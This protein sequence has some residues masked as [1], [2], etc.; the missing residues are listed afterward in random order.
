MCFFCAVC[1]GVSPKS[2]KS[3]VQEFPVQEFPMQD[4]CQE[5]TDQ[6][7]YGNNALHVF[8]NVNEN[9]SRH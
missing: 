3:F 7:D 6:T 9:F 5:I 2:I 4:V 8:V 1:G